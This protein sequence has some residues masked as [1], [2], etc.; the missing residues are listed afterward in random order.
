MFV[1]YI[2]Q[3]TMISLAIM[4]SMYL[5]GLFPTTFNA[6]PSLLFAFTWLQGFS[7]FGFII[8][9]CALLPQNMYP[10]LAAKWGTL[11]YFGSAFADFTI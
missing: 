9:I 2:T 4:F 3:I 10:K 1:S 11:I 7:N 8:M 5:G 6:A